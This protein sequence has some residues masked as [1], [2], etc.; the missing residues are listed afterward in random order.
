[1]FE[2]ALEL[3][4][5]PYARTILRELTEQPK[6]APEVAERCE[7]SRVTVYRRLADLEAAGLVRAEVELSA[8]GHHRHV[9]HNVLQRLTVSICPDGM[10][11]DVSVGRSP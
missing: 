1:M 3:L 6:S 5:D 9:Y 8:S 7:F 11:G 4:S 2:D 10:E